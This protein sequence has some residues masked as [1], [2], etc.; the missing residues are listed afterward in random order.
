MPWWN[1]SFLCDVACICGQ[2]WPIIAG[3]EG[4]RRAVTLHGKGTS[5]TMA[6]ESGGMADK[7]G[8]RFEKRWVIRQLLL[9]IAGRIRALQ[10]EP[11]GHEGAG[12]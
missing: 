12:L 9:L 7:Q 11:A 10:Y 8:N 3:V 2:D 5:R 1:R 4:E 6:Y